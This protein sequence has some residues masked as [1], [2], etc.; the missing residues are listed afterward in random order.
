VG[1]LAALGDA[2][3]SLNDRNAGKLTW[4]IRPMVV[5]SPPPF[6]LYLRAIASFSDLKAKPVKPTFGGALG[7][8]FGLF[9][10]GGFVEAGAIQHRYQV[11]VSGTTVAKDGWQVEGRVGISIG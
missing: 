2:K 10:I 4:D 8:G 7:V 11:D 9:G 6:P 5:V 1:A 3:A